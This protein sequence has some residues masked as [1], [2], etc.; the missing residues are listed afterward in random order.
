MPDVGTVTFS[1]TPGSERDIREYVLLSS[2]SSDS[3]TAVEVARGKSSPITYTPPDYYNRYYWIKVEDYSGNLS[4]FSNMTNGAPRRAASTDVGFYF[5]DSTSQGGSAKFVDKL[6]S[7]QLESSHTVDVYGSIRLHSGGDLLTDHGGL[8]DDA[9]RI[10]LDGNGNIGCKG[11]LIPTSSSYDL[12][13]SFYKWGR[14]YASHATLGTAGVP[15]TLHVKD[16][17]SGT[18]TSLE[19]YIT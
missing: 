17:S 14:L 12:G 10:L 18:W 9:G 8:Y 16:P 7:A 5:A 13:S 19:A 4:D 1:F 2:L 15:L 6:N 3:N 11:D